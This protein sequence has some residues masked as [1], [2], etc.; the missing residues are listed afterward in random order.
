MK[1]SALLALLG[2]AGA[3]AALA[4]DDP[5]DRIGD[6]LAYSGFGDTLRV[7][8]SGTVDLEA[9]DFQ[10]PSSDL[11]YTPD[12]QLLNPRLTVFLD[13]QIGPHLY[14][15]A[16]SRLDRGF[17]PANRRAQLRLDE[18]ALRYSPSDDGRFNLQL[19]KFAT[20][21]GNWVGRHLS[22]E[23]PFITAPLPYANLTG[24]FDAE[25]ARSAEVLRYWAHV[26]PPRP[27]PDEYTDPLWRVPVIWGPSYTAGAAATGTLG[28][29]DYAVEW[30]NASLSSRPYAWDPGRNEW[31]HPTFSGRLGYRPDEMWNFGL[32]AST[33]TYLRPAA[34]PTLAPGT[35][36]DEYRE[37]VL[38]QDLAFAW[39]HF[40]LW[41]ECFEARFAIPLVGHAD[42]LA[43]YVEAKY[44]FTPQFSGA[45]RWGQ[46]QFGDVRTR[47]GR[48]VPW[49]SDVWRFEVA[50]TYRF[51]AH[52]E[53]KLQYSLQHN[54]VGRPV[55]SHL[56]AAQFV[57]RF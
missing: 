6:A 39:H 49:G 57:I 51:T 26:A 54:A 8:L 18:Y 46:Q 17:D 52:L 30:K 10:R 37:T 41:A 35:D 44:K 45:G 38:G 40:Q 12:S 29:W 32:S 23:N 55:Y 25:A 31:Q 22:W 47:D 53:G 7:Q 56:A 24:I 2:A 14:L 15:F 1:A 42:T 50:P 48:L 16:Q 13:A 9:Y 43:Y 4:A 3:G 34:A 19:G 27:V 36:L 33:G 21:V 11:I 28:R 20:V 5:L